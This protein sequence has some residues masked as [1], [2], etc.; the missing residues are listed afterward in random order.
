[1]KKLRA[2]V[3]GGGIN[4]AVGRVHYEALKMANIDVIDGYFSRDPTIDRKSRTFWGL[5]NDEK[6]R[7]LRELSLKHKNK[8][9]T[10]LVAIVLTPTTSHHKDI[11]CLLRDNYNVICEKPLTVTKEEVE[12]LAEI[13]RDKGKIIRCT[14]NYGG[15]PMFRE[16]VEQVRE[17]KIGVIQQL[18]LQMPQEGLVK[19]PNIS[20]EKKP[21]QEWRLKDPKN[22]S[23]ANLDLGAHLY[24]MGKM[25]S[26]EDI[27][28]VASCMTN[29][30]NYDK[31]QDTTYAIIKTRSG[32]RGIFWL[33]K[34]MFGTRNGLQI[35]VSGDKGTLK[36]KQTDPETLELSNAEIL[37]QIID[38]GGKCIEANKKRYDRMKPGHPAGYIEAFA[39]T[40]IDIQS[41]I[42]QWQET[43]I[44]ESKYG[45]DIRTSIEIARFLENIKEKSMG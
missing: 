40:Y 39:N 34:S 1:M 4:S 45:L 36:W 9:E 26:N 20:G 14:Y 10:Y 3:I 29:Y 2:I 22:T 12:E 43:G 32:I 16:M 21:P 27:E 8:S 18:I 33:T 6:H 42:L 37:S 7:D 44:D 35:T 5:N 17:K 41:E 11:K 28:V 38:R 23:M 31:I 24:Q 25:I 13:A 15:Y 19:P 30:T